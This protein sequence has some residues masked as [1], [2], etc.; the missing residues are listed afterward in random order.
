MLFTAVIITAGLTFNTALHDLN[1]AA[2]SIYRQAL[3]A[4]LLV[5][6]ETF[7]Q[8][9]LS[10]KAKCVGNVKVLRASIEG[11]SYLQKL[12]DNLQM[13]LKKEDIDEMKRAV[14]VLP[15]PYQQQSIEV[16]KRSLKSKLQTFKDQTKF[17]T[18]QLCLLGVFTATTISSS[19]TLAIVGIISLFDSDKYGI[20]R[21][22][23]IAITVVGSALLATLGISAKILNDKLSP[24]ETRSFDDNSPS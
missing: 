21:E 6:E 14:S 15:C 23:A 22:V 10:G 20:S 16:S 1:L 7:L 4:G 3:E 13:T 2:I 8:C 24:P 11:N 19:S 9:L 17:D 18:V 5:N 12:M